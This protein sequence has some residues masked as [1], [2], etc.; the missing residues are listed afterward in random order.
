MAATTDDGAP[1]GEPKANP[2]TAEHYQALQNVLATGHILDDAILR[3]HHI[4]G[5]H[6]TV[7]QLAAQ[8]ERD[9][10]VAKRA[11]AM[12]PPPKNPIAE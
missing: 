8:H 9:Q 6:P 7:G 1:Q 5:D 2:L 3:A 4:F 10:K 11:L 12:Y